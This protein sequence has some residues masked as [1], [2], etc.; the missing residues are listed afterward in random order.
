MMGLLWGFNQGYR[1]QP[2]SHT[3]EA[4]KLADIGQMGRKRLIGAMVIA[5]AV[6]SL[7]AYWAFIEMSYRGGALTIPDEVDLTISKIG[8]MR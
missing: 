4:F 2:M 8:Y 1:A 7:S 3:L 6:G 5:T